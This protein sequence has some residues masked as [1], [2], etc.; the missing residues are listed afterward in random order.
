MAGP[1]DDAWNH[2]MEAAFGGLQAVPLTKSARETTGTLT[3][4]DLGDVVVFGISGTA[5]H[6][7]RQV[8][9]ARRSA[10]ELVKIC[11]VRRGRCIIEQAGREV[12]IGPGQFALYHTGLPYRITWP[13]SWECDVMTAFPSKL[14]VPPTAL[15]D[16]RARPWSTTTGAGAVLL[17][18]I[19]ACVSMPQPNPV[20]RDQLASAGASLLSGA[21]LNDL[22]PV[23]DDA[24]GVLREQVELYVERSLRDPE[25]SVANI[26]AAHHVSIRTIQRLFAGTGKNLS[27]IIRQRRLEAVRRD[28]TDL[29]LGYLT[30]AEVAARWCIHDAQ[31]LAKAF[32]AEFGLPPSEFRRSA[33]ADS[34]VHE[35]RPLGLLTDGPI[36]AIAGQG[37]S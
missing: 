25:L 26:A 9:A 34:Q 24:P 29:R 13:D 10:T 3:S 28:L 4:T 33:I 19:T 7:V 2:D 35:R 21:I 31:W 23:I 32:K 8:G 30:I 22:Y 27:R 5:Q 18:F 6:L 14:G 1:V 17:Q 15:N 12:A 37:L 20:V 36:A 16:A 11:A